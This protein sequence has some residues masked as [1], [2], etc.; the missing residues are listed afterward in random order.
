MK[1]NLMFKFLL[2][3]CLFCMSPGVG[4]SA[5]LHTDTPW[6]L[7]IIDSTSDG[8]DGVRLGDVNG[9]GLP[10][11][12]TGWEEGGLV[13]VYL[14]PGHAESAQHWPAV[15][16]GTVADVEDA[17]FADLN[18]DG[19]LE[20]VSSCEG[21]HR[22]MY[23][24]R[25]AHKDDDPLLPDNW[26]TEPLE[27]ASGLMQWMFS[28][29]VVMEPDGMTCLAAG[30]KNENAELG[31]FN[32]P[33]PSG[34]WHWNPL[35]KLG[36]VMSIRV[37][38][39]D[40]DGD[41]DI[42]FTDR[43]GPRRGVRWLENPGDGGL[44]WKEHLI[45]G[46]DCELMFLDMGDLDGDG[47]LELA[48]AAKDRRILIFDSQPGEGWS[49]YEITYPD[50]TG[51]AK[52]VAIADFDLDGRNDLVVSCESAVNCSGVFWIRSSSWPDPGEVEYFDIAGPRGIKF[53]R[54]ECVDIDGDGDPDV[55]TTDERDD[56]G[57]IW[58][59]NP[60]N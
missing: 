12:A 55:L 33:D 8:A 53:D 32:R 43:K 20:V 35:A 16:V 36:W 38:D 50:N 40:G 6:L 42:L 7:H 60:L 57:V 44:E 14:H 24:H 2:I 18:G 48:V 41:M 51:R 37:P 31:I 22:A 46:Q 21:D 19:V 49:R 10:D 23:I 28:A 45:G 39:M 17:V 54:I 1:L 34:R 58:Y 9:D 13:R 29:P 11:I 5:T 4:K 52:A 26:L 59:E 25:L 27:A 56:L 15:T 30:A 47:Q 3:P